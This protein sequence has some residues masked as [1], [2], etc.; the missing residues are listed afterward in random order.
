MALKLYETM[1]LQDADAYI[2]NSP[3]SAAR[4]KKRLRDT[5]RRR[6][7]VLEKHGLEKTQGYR[8]MELAMRDSLGPVTAEALSRMT[9]ILGS[10]RTSYTGWLGIQKKALDTINLEFGVWK[11]NPKTKLQELVKPFINS[12]AE[13]PEFY[14]MLDWFKE[15][16]IGFAYRKKELNQIQ[17]VRAKMQ[18]RGETWQDVKLWLEQEKERVFDAKEEPDIDAIIKQYLELEEDEE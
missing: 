5:M 10:A 16:V 9:N 6:M 12:L 1:S 13:L 11:E 14:D 18:E 4:M 8:W 15:N 2:M 17:D 3:K 7:R